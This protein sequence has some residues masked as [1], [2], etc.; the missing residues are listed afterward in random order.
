MTYNDEEGANATYFRQKDGELE[1]FDKFS[2]YA[3]FSSACDDVSFNS[4]VCRND[5]TNRITEVKGKLSKNA[6]INTMIDSNYLKMEKEINK[7]NTQNA[8]LINQPYLYERIDNSGNLFA[9]TIPSI[10]DARMI[11][12][13]HILLKQNT[14][15][16]VCSLVISS[17]LI[18]AIIV[19]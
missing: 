10:S 9:E 3:S 19:Q 16:I 12:S 2:V 13:Q 18:L 14:V 11:D 7:Y 8:K 15:H 1:S 6:E 17:L 5:I 4:T